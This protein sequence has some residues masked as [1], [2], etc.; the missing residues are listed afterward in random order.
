M[1]WGI[2]KMMHEGDKIVRHQT[3][4][5]RYRGHSQSAIATG[6][7]AIDRDAKIVDVDGSRVRLTGK[8]YEMLELLSQSRGASVTREALM[9]HL[10]RGV[11][12]PKP[13]IITVFICKVRKKLAAAACGDTRIDTIRGRGYVLRDRASGDDSIDTPPRTPRSAPSQTRRSHVASG[14]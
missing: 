11:D 2:A 12:E 7:L 13:R 3:L 8:E 1:T 6:K 10:Y 9:D 5:R 4:L 14:A